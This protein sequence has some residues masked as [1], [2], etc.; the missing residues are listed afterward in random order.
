M[1]P[2][3]VIVRF[4]LTSTQRRKGVEKVLEDNHLAAIKRV[5]NGWEFLQVLTDEPDQ[6]NTVR[7]KNNLIPCR[8]TVVQR[9]PHFWSKGYEKL[10]QRS[11]IKRYAKQ[12]IRCLCG[13]V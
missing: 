9:K 12:A 10:K 4:Y 8:I 5:T 13:L 6:Y 7:Y 2:Y 1:E 11:G 3:K